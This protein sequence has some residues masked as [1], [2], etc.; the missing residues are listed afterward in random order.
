M[1]PYEVGYYETLYKLGF[2]MKQAAEPATLLPAGPIS[3]GKERAPRTYNPRGTYGS[4]VASGG[5][6]KSPTLPLTRVT[7]GQSAPV[8]TPSEEGAGAL[9]KN[10]QTVRA[11]K[12]P[13]PVTTEL[14]SGA[15]PTTVAGGAT[16]SK[17]L[18]ANVSG[19][20]ASIP[21]PPPPFGAK[22]APTASD[23]AQMALNAGKAAPAA[24][25]PS[26]VAT[27]GA[28]PT[29]KPVFRGMLTGL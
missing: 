4:S 1:T 17:R 8:K 11:S 24:A 5:T 13:K 2:A 21:S 15:P 22:S 14:Q 29:P 9:A 16:G 6:L 7:G 18:P 19:M 27:S 10:T 3:M 26:A 23:K 12:T 25:A 20:L 28:K